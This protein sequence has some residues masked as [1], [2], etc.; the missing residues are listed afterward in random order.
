MKEIL[1]SNDSSVD[2]ICQLM[3]GISYLFMDNAI[4]KNEEKSQIFNNILSTYL[5]KYKEKILITVPDPKSKKYIIFNNIKSQ[6]EYSKDKEEKRN[7]L[8]EL[9]S[10]LPNNIK[11][12]KK[13]TIGAE[14]LNIVKKELN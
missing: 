7:I 14:I 6:F 9:M 1:E 2:H 12:I 13:N 4:S 3:P 11:D 10:L 8:G 5:H